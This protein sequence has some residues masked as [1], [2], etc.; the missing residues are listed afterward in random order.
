VNDVRICGLTREWTTYAWLCASCREARFARGW[1]VALFDTPSAYE[2]RVFTGLC[3][4]CPAP[5]QPAAVDFVATPRE[6]R[7]DDLPPP[8]VPMKRKGKGLGATPA[9]S[10][11]AELWEGSA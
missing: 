11:M 7:P 8:F 4:D 3:Q 10:P 2:G 5:A 9:R 6:P 1:K